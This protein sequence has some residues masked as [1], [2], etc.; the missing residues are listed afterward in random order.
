M[1]SPLTIGTTAIVVAPINK[2][3]DLVRFQNTGATIFYIKKVPFEGVFTLPSATDYEVL[4]Q[5]SSS[6]TEAGD[7][8]ETNSV[9]A[10]AAVSSAVGGILSVYETS[11]V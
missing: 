5:P 7:A 3:R 11:K 9:A 6:L 2:K 1:A 8:F 10:F 4:M